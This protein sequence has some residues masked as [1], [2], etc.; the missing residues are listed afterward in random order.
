MPAGDPAPAIEEAPPLRPTENVLGSLDV[1]LTRQLRFGR[2]VI[3][4]TDQRLV[5]RFPDAT[6]WQAWDLHPGLSLAHHDHAGVGTLELHDAQGRLAVWR[7]TLG[8]N[9]AALR[10][11]GQFE[12]AREA[13]AGG[14]PSASEDVAPAD[15]AEDEEGVPDQPPS[16]WTLLRLWRFARPYQWQL[17]AGFV[18]MLAATAATL[19]PPYL[20]MPLM[21]K[22]LIP[23][24]SGQ[25]IDT[26]YVALLLTGLLGSA[27]LAWG[28]GWAKTYILALVSERIGADLRTITYE[29]LLKLSLEY[30]GGRRTG[31]LMARIGSE[32]DRINIFLSLHLLDFATDVLMIAMTAAILFSIDPTLALVT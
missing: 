2:G 15:Q 5:T 29:H 24:Q 27:L 30:F 19:V 20:T 22:V 14:A 4:I 18:L 32:T 13:L 10:L 12:R 21:D 25:Q 3:L 9:P 16:T 26:G 6:G 1:D 28:L 11:L 17:L 23:F 7:Y 31:D 8:H